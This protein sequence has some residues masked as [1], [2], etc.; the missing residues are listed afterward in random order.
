MV[1]ERRA[2]F[3]AGGHHGGGGARESD[4]GDATD[5][6]VWHGRWRWE[7]AEPGETD[8]SLGELGGRAWAV[9]I[10][11]ELESRSEQL[12]RHSF[13]PA[14]GNGVLSRMRNNALSTYTPLIYQT[15]M[16]SMSHVKPYMYGSGGPVP[17][18]QTTI[19]A[20]PFPG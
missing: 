3:V 5:A 10:Q 2:V 15:C 12:E 16:Y 4:S 19:T 13:V 17:A 8:T 11:R 9:S 7:A 14:T 1:K 6:A 20:Y 18:I